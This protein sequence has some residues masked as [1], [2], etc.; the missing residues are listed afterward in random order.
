MLTN[1]TSIMTST[2]RTTTHPIWYLDFLWLKKTY[3]LLPGLLIKEKMNCHL[4]SLRRCQCP[5]T[6]FPHMAPPFPEQRC[7]PSGRP[8][9]GNL[10]T[11]A[12][13]FASVQG[14]I[15]L[16]HVSTCYYLDIN[17][18][19]PSNGSPKGGR[20]SSDCLLNL[21]HILVV[22]WILR[23]VLL[24]STSTSKLM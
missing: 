12:V 1:I 16:I 19:P 9:S 23:S 5:G 4:Q 15:H 3:L 24:V 14:L 18:Y 6:L 2:R 10:M 8:G 11:W 17:W 21:V 7:K 20:Q 22:S 13:A